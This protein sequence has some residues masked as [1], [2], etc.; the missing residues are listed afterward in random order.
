M[1]PADSRDA[2]ASGVS[3][4]AAPPVSRSTHPPGWP[5]RRR[6]EVRTVS[7]AALGELTQRLFAEVVAAWGSVDVIVAIATGGVHVANALPSADRPPVLTCR[8]QRPS[9]KRRPRPLRLSNLP[10]LLTD[11]LRRLED[12]AAARRSSVTLPEPPDLARDLDAVAAL[13]GK[14]GWTR[15]LVLDDAVDSGVTLAAVTGGLRRRLG[16]KAEVRSAAITQTRPEPAE[17]PG[18]VIYRGVLCR[19][20]WSDDFREGA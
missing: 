7:P 8:L 5:S 14:H 1:A 11:E 3:S 6:K 4:F 19:F 10:Y 17:L 13:A 18:V 16:A 9:T 12:G 15:V 20:P 2:A